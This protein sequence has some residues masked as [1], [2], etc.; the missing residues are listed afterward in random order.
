[1]V[2]VSKHHQNQ[3]ERINKNI[4]E[5]YVYFKKNREYF[6]SM[7]NFVL[8]TTLTDDQRVAL[9]TLERPKLEF[10]VLEAFISRLLGEFSKQIPGINVYADPTES[11][12]PDKTIEFVQNHMRHLISSLRANEIYKD[13]LTGGFSCM[14][15][16]T[17]Y[18]NSKS[19]KQ[20]I[21]VDR[22]FDPLLIGFD[23]AAQKSHK[24]DGSYCFE[25]IP[26]S[27]DQFKDQYPDIDV[28][29]CYKGSIQGFKWGYKSNR[30]NI[31][32]VASYYEKKSRKEMIYELPNGSTLTK[33]EYEEF[34]SLYEKNNDIRQPPQPVNKRTTRVP[35]VVRYILIS[36]QIIEYSETSFCGLP[37]I[38]VDG[39]SVIL[40]RDTEG[41]IMEQ[42]TRSYIHNAV[43][44]QKLKN[45]CGQT[46]A[47]EIESMV[48]HKMKISLESIE[49]GYEDE[50]RNPQMM[51]NYIY[52]QYSDDGQRQ[53]NPP[54]E[55]QK[56]PLPPEIT[57]TFMGID[58]I[59]QSSLGSY[60]AS[61]GIN[62]N[63]LSG[64]AIVEGATQSNAAA[65]PFV[66]NYLS[67]LQQVAEIILDL[68]P[69]FY[70]TPRSMPVITS[71]D[72]KEHIT[73]NDPNNAESPTMKFNSSDLK[74]VVK[75]GVNFE[76][77]KTRA[78]QM[79][80]ELSQ[81][82]P[83]MAQIINNPKGL[84]IVADNLSFKG[85]DQIKAIAEEAAEKQKEAEEQAQKSQASGQN[86]PPPN[87]VMQ[88]LALEAQKIASKS[89]AEMA[90]LAIRKQEADTKQM[91]AMVNAAESKAEIMM[92]SKR[93]Q[94]ERMVH[95]INAHLKNKEINN[96]RE[97]NIL[98]TATEL[99]KHSTPVSV[100][101]EVSPVS[102]IVPDSTSSQGSP[103]Q[104]EYL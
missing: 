88:K 27:E 98:N 43:G 56:V 67:S 7:R 47:N 91:T 79:L 10:N 4:N 39:N 103:P 46:I 36:N 96:N 18:E 54:M 44:C 82:L 6:N 66:I 2:N 59:I 90:S 100:P 12:P 5:S 3:L 95:Q 62:K 19:F 48:T 41:G 72:K 76:V 29:G 45:I 17:E 35:Y 30:K 81:A 68:I 13:Q 61:L 23:P 32:M 34:L 97:K 52:K 53:L 15:I 80:F 24:G 83:G 99:K 22:V 28:T 89:Q 49:K 57:G 84:A 104:G 60:D 20:R 92:Q 50:Y 38:F 9:D 75:A 77:Q 55:V 51:S 69:K 73:I 58:N 40:R 70:I 94:T 26:L 93:D 33:D 31:I 63:Q 74:V 25:I 21:C 14:K 86:Q 102:Q 87:P 101:D 8:N 85:A 1:M 42:V 71:E 78:L 64:V 16:W 37:L 65:M 11:I